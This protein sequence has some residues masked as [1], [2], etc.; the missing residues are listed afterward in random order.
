MRRTAAW[1]GSAIALFAVT[2]LL[3]LGNRANLLDETWMLWVTK[4]MTS[5]DRLYSD[6]YFVSTPLAAWLSAAFALVGGVQLTVL[7]ALEVTVFV[8]ELLVATSVA[9]WCR[10][11]RPSLVLF[12]GALFAIGAP[13]TEWIS[14]YSSVAVLFALVALRVLLV[15]LDSRDEHEGERTRVWALA[16]VGAACGASFAAKPNI[17]L[18]A[19]AAALASMWVNRRGPTARAP[20]PLVRGLLV[21][22][23]AFVAVPLLAAVKI[24][25]QRANRDSR[26][27]VVLED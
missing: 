17:G 4:R 18:L 23:G 11:S 12:G 13:A 24:F 22:T 20:D 10:L 25:A 27:A 15:W 8:A 16:G 6:V 5:G 14:V 1:I 7:R 21:V 26:L 2:Y 9:R 19:L 3:V